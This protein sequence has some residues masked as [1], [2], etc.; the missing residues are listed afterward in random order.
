MGEATDDWTSLLQ[1]PQLLPFGQVNMQNMM[2]D[3]QFTAMPNLNRRFSVQTPQPTVQ[4]PQ[5][6]FRTTRSASVSFTPITSRYSAISAPEALEFQPILSQTTEAL[7]F[8]PGPQNPSL[9]AVGTV[10]YAAP[11]NSIS[12]SLLKPIAPKSLRPPPDAFVS[13]DIDGVTMFECQFTG[14]KKR[15]WF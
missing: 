4:I 12:T 7:E 11:S 13:V 6:Q 8:H 14:C 15:Y 3:P 10:S 5:Q 1:T 9:F 2:Y